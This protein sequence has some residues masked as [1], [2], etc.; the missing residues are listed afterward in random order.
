MDKQ[1]DKLTHP[2]GKGEPQSYS[3]ENNTDISRVDFIISTE[4]INYVAPTNE[5]NSNEKVSGLK[6]WLNILFGE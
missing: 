6:K 5:I 4:A 3:S 1:I 2:G